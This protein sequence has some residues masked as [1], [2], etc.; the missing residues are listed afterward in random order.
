MIGQLRIGFTEGW[1]GVSEET[2]GSI[3]G[4]SSYYFQ[5]EQGIET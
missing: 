4:A 2:P 3:H 1:P 5:T